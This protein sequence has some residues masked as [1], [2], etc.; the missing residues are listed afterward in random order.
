MSSQ[1]IYFITGAGRGIG[2]AL[3]EKLASDTNNVI[4]AGV[5]DTNLA[6]DHPLAKL[7]A[8]KPDTIHLIKIS[9]ANKEDNEA[10]AQV[11]K[12][13]YGRVD[14]VIANAGVTS[15]AQPI[16]TV[17]AETI[18][19]DFTI[20]TIGPVILFQSFASL[21]EASKN[22]KF[23]VISSLLGQIAESLPWPHNAY[24]LSKAGVNF[25]AK[26]IDQE[27]ETIISF[28]IQ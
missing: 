23:V 25:V 1:T 15:G 16:R 5:R 8:K 20:N 10:A 11:V 26:K 7:V 21:L 14:V 17:S 13:Q 18:Q 4:L 27:H 6:A 12:E 3:V 22:A 24:G 28:P 9:S 2:L 19:A